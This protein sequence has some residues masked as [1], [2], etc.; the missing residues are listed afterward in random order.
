MASRFQTPLLAMLILAVAA[1]GQTPQPPAAGNSRIYI[2]LKPSVADPGAARDAFAQRM[3]TLGAINLQFVGT[4]NAARCEVPAAA[5]AAIGS[6]PDVAGVLPIDAAPATAPPTAPPTLPPAPS[7]AIATPPYFPPPPNIPISAGAPMGGG[8]NAGI[9]MLT[10]FA[11]NVVVK[12]LT[13]GTA[14]KIRIHGQVPVI[15]ASGG[16]GAFEVSASGNCAWQAVSTADWLRVKSD[17]NA[18]GTVAVVYSASGNSSGHRQAVVVIQ[19]FA[20]MAA[21][22][23]HTVV[24]VGQQ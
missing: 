23:G 1:L 20:G 6:D 5:Q 10:D 18:N 2:L 11:G 24:L 14:C 13:P 16:S 4:A 9:T 7:P 17:I 12:L 15:P 22:K 21:L 19:P 8:M 3:A